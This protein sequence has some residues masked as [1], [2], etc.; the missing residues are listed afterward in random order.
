MDFV[1]Q[2]RDALD[3]I[4]HDDPVGRQCPKLQAK[5]C[6]VGEECLISALV[7]EVDD[8]RIGERLTGPGAFADP[9]HPV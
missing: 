9:T 5:Q 4:E 1:E 2:R 7:E 6:R 3:F 8:V